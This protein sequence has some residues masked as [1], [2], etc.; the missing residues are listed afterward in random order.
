MSMKTAM[1]KEKIREMIGKLLG[2]IE[3]E[4]VG[5]SLLN[6]HYQNQEEL[7]FFTPED[8]ERVMVILKKLSDDSHRHKKLL[9][10]IVT[11]LGKK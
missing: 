5:I 7:A 4:E 2:E 9:E 6:T 3:E 10:K 8:R 1:T 11:Q